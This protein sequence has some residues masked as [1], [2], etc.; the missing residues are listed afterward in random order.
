M[1]INSAPKDSAILSNVS[2]VGEFSIKASAK[3]FSILSQSLYGNTIKAICRELSTNAH[4]SHIAAGNKDTPFDVHLPNAL[5]PYYSIR[6]YGTGLS[7]EQVTDIYTVYFSSTKTDSNDY[8]GALGLG[9]KSPFSYTTNFTVT[10]IKDGRKGIYTAFINDS[11]VPSIA[12]MIEESTT[13]PNGVEIRFAVESHSDFQKF[14]DES[15]QVYKYF[16]L[17]PVVTGNKDYKITEIEYKEKDIIPGVHQTSS[18]N[19][20]AVMGNIIAHQ[21]AQC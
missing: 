19:C 20:V 16:P 11:G 18:G 10:A 9:S 6:D 12:R 2:D 5:E 17:K 15:A 4:D 14:R 7:H 1:I 8:V 3:S 13:E 21:Y